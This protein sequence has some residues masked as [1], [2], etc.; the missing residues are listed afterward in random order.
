M[1]AREGVSCHTL[2]A[3]S[4][5]LCPNCSHLVANLRLLCFLLLF[6]F[7]PFVAVVVASA[8]VSKLPHKARHTRVAST[9]TPPSQES[10]LP[11]VAVTVN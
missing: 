11:P 8:R 5:D 9:N 2:A 6:F 3:C 4:G 1:R 10:P 7:T